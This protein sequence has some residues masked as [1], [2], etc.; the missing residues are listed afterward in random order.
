MDN[1]LINIDKIK[2]E[3]KKGKISIFNNYSLKINKGEFLGIYGKSGIGKSTLLDI[4]AG[5]KNVKEGSVMVKGRNISRFSE[6]EKCKYRNDVIGFIY[7]DFRLIRE[8]TAIENVM[9]PLI[10]SKCDVRFARQKAIEILDKL[11][12]GNRLGNYPNQLSGGEKQRVAIA[13]AII[14]NPDIILADEPTGN[15]DEDN[16]K[17]IMA[18]LKRIN[19]LGG[20][21]VMVTHDETCRKYFSRDLCLR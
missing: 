18:I 8:L 7:Q 9:I 12:M 10:I 21:I 14:N 3:Y 16:K 2:F 5:T 4:I 13:R 15:L 11:E 6:K 20:T 17:E 19:E 1:L